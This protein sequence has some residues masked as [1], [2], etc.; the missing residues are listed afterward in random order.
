MPGATP[1]ADALAVLPKGTRCMA[2]HALGIHGFAV[3]SRDGKIWGTASTAAGAWDA[4]R[5]AFIRQGERAAE[6]DKTVL[7]ALRACHANS[8]CIVAEIAA[9][10][11]CSVVHNKRQ[12][13]AAV[14]KQLLDME[15]RGL[16]KRAD[17]NKPILWQ[18]A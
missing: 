8:G 14:S 11:P 16:I 13:S 12:H 15:A 10:V 2:V 5:T 18:A 3:H 4:A 1:K 6:F 17:A 9:L 7:K